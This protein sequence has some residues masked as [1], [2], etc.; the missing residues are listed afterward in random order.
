LPAVGCDALSRPLGC[1]CEHYSDFRVEEEISRLRALSP[2]C[3]GI[4]ASYALMAYA[5][6]ESSLYLLFSHEVADV[7]GLVVWL[8]FVAKIFTFRACDFVA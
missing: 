3:H 2:Q 1:R 5:L 7:V 8:A 6:A 4:I